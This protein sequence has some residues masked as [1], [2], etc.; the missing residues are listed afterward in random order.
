M[1]IQDNHLVRDIKQVPEDR[2]ED[3][4]ELPEELAEAAERKL[5]GKNEATVSKNSGG[6]LSRWAASERRRQKG[7]AAK[8]HKARREHK[9]KSANRKKNKSARKSRRKNRSRR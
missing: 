7:L 3:Y 1:N 9:M 8:Q 2:R 4:T 5:A 6:K